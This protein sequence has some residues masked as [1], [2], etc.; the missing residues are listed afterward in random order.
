MQLVVHIPDDLIEPVRDRL[1]PP[2]M[3]VLESV[4][5]DAI[6]GFLDTL[7]RGKVGLPDNKTGGPG[8]YRTQGR[9]SAPPT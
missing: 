1:P 6:I 4:A 8:A 9:R 7:Q 5:L 2:E 3:G